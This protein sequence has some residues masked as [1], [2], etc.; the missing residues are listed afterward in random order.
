[1]STRS[2]IAIKNKDG[3]IDSIYC[4]YDGYLEYNGKI[5]NYYYRDIEKIKDLLDLGDISSLNIKIH[6]DPKF[7]HSFDIEE[8]QE[9]VVVSYNRDRGESNVKKKHFDTM[10][11]YKK[12]V[13]DSWM[14]YSYIYDERTS[15]WYYSSIPKTNIAEFKYSELVDELIDKNLLDIKIEKKTKFANE[16]VQA[17]KDIDY[18][19]FIDSCYSYDK[20]FYIVNEDLNNNKVDY[21]LKF[22]NGYKEEGNNSYDNIIN[23]LTDYEKLISNDR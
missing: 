2:S 1:M 7:K 6:P 10:I 14:E 5:L 9:D 13:M 4:H 22:F 12:Y 21:L 20:A 18:Y 15:K 8:R 19:E 23:K 3:S 17:I 16:I 11:D